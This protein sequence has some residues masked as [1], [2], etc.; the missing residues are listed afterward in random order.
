MTIKDKW[1]LVAEAALRAEA[2]AYGAPPLVWHRTD[3]SVRVAMIAAVRAAVAEA[4]QLGLRVLSTGEKRR[5][6]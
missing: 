6:R 1:A 4:D 2:M 3:E 5:R